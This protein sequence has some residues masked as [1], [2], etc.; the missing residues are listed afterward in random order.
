MDGFPDERVHRYN[1][2]GLAGLANRTVPQRPRRLASDQLATLA[3]WVEAGPDLA[4]DGVVRWRRR[5]LQHRLAVEFGVL[6]ECRVGH[7]T[8]SAGF[9]AS[10]GAPA[11]PEVGPRGA[12]G[13]QK[14]RPRSRSG[15]SPG[16]GTGQA[17]GNLVSR[18]S[19]G[20]TIGPR[21]MANARVGQQGT[22]TRVWARRGTR[23]RAVRDTRSPGPTCSA[24]SAPH[25]RSRRASSC[26]APPRQ[27]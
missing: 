16:A 7:A 21:P 2:E 9:P 27:R 20:A 25:V 14:K 1:A 18:V 3:A 26:P 10:V 24:P 13:I 17:A 23:P 12:G 6:H 5:D 15:G 19:H 4:R 11:A 22:L 8:G